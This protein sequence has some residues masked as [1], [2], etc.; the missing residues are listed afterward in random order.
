MV[1]FYYRLKQFFIGFLVF[2][3]NFGPMNKFF[4][5]LIILLSSF[6]Q[7]VN[8]QQ[9]TV[10]CTPQFDNSIYDT[11]IKTVKFGTINN[12]HSTTAGSPDYTYFN[13]PIADVNQCQTYTLTV[14]YE[15]YSTSTNISAFFDFNGDGNFSGTAEVFSLKTGRGSLTATK[16]ITIPSTAP[17]KRIRMRIV[18]NE[19][20]TALACDDDT[21][22][23]AEDYELLVKTGVDMTFQSASV[24]Q[25][26]ISVVKQG[27]TKKEILGVN[28]ITQN[29][30]NP[31]D[32]TDMT[33]ATTGSTDP[34]DISNA[35]L[36]YNTTNDFSG[37]TVVGGT[38]VSP[39]GNFTIS[40]IDGGV[41]G[42]AVGNNY[43]W[44]AY[45]ISA[46]AT[47]KNFVDAELIDIKTNEGG[48]S[49]VT[50][51]NSNP[52]GARE[53]IYQHCVPV[54]DAATTGDDFELNSYSLANYTSRAAADGFNSNDATGYNNYSTE[55]SLILCAGSSYAFTANTTN[56]DVNNMAFV[57]FWADWN[58]DGDF[59]DLDEHQVLGATGLATSAIVLITTTNDFTTV[60]RVPEHAKNGYTVARV[61]LSTDAKNISCGN[62]AKGE[63][64][65]VLIR[66]NSF[67]TTTNNY[68]YNEDGSAI[69]LSQTPS[70][71]GYIWQKSTDLV[72]FT[73]EAGSNDALNLGVIPTSTVSAYRLNKVVAECPTDVDGNTFVQSGVTEVLKV[74]LDSVIAVPTEVCLG[75]SSYLK[76]YYGFKSQIFTDAPADNFTGQGGAYTGTITVANTLPT[77]KFNLS[78]VCVDITASLIEDLAFEL[79]SPSGKKVMLFNGSSVNAASQNYTFC[80][81]LDTTLVNINDETA[82]LSGD[83]QPLTS[84]SRLS[85]ETTNGDWN[86]NI[87]SSN[88]AVDATLNSWSMQFGHNHSIDWTDATTFF[89]ASLDSSKAQVNA[90]QYFTAS[91]NS[92]L[93]T[94][95]NFIDSVEVISNDP[96]NLSIDRFESIDGDLLLCPGAD[97]Q[98]K[99][100]LTNPIAGD[101]Y[102]WYVNDV[103]VVGEDRDSIIINTLN[104]GDELKVEFTLNSTCGTLFATDSVELFER[105][106]VIPAIDLTSSIVGPLCDPTDFTIDAAFTDTLQQAMYS[107]RINANEVAQKVNTYDFIGLNNGDTIFVSVT[108]SICSTDYS[109]TDTIIY[110]YNPRVDIVGG[111]VDNLTEYCFGNTSL[112]FDSTGNNVSGQFYWVL[113]SDTIS[114]E[115]AINL[116]TLDAGNYDIS[117]EYVPYGCFTAT[118][119]TETHSFEILEILSPAITIDAAVKILCP[120]EGVIIKSVVLENAGVNPTFTWYQNGNKL[121][122]ETNDSLE[123]IN[124]NVAKTYYVELES[125][126]LCPDQSKV[127][128]NILKI[129]VQ[130]DAVVKLNSSSSSPVMGCVDGDDVV[131]TGTLTDA[132]ADYYYW[133]AND[134]IIPNSN[135][136][137]VTFPRDSGMYT[138]RLYGVRDFVCAGV[139][140]VESS[141]IHKFENYTAPDSTFVMNVVAGEYVASI[142]DTSSEATAMWYLN[143]KFISANNVA[144]I[145][146]TKAL[147]TLCVEVSMAN[148]CVTSSCQ[149]F[150]FVGVEE[151]IVNNVSVYPNPSKSILNI[152]WSGISENG[153]V[154][155]TIINQVGK[156]IELGELKNASISVEGLAKGSYILQLK[157]NDSYAI[158]RFE[159]M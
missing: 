143:G 153:V 81:T 60:I 16:Q 1:A 129:E 99:A 104:D 133:T 36:Y 64:D 37:A 45:N 145:V 102:T 48:G 110:Q 66:V 152:Q 30:C 62:F 106:A 54:V 96:G 20:S 19:N 68:A 116:D 22:G 124:Q 93:T 65:D 101:N 14:T 157:S 128:S 40:N 77:S 32:V 79:E 10:N 149:E 141:G 107:W 47:N 13:T 6:A 131:L 41:N 59:D 2:G 78:K 25:G 4:T 144:T 50:A 137:N 35:R 119:L 52:S 5:F 138:Y 123:I 113:N 34:S 69:T 42:L 127:T 29:A 75:D 98:V 118:N 114:N 136:L 53:I 154:E 158:K 26:P 86:L 55:D 74:G 151:Q 71:S 24:S 12:N 61:G 23:E 120:L 130:K 46:S 126:Y 150:S 95:T 76:S 111:L 51:S 73:D 117:V 82:A 100:I 3:C 8:A 43:F 84:W 125:D 148:T 134:T 89:N 72:S 139:D 88:D 21:Y 91:L 121:N 57:Q 56:S 28:V 142:N 67:E 27:E 122:F 103:I 132:P 156:T 97:K 63:F 85:G 87:L 155:Y 58:Q 38:A 31:I 140:T 70:I 112:T 92:D 11:Y 15:A 49:L 44:L 135:S 90:T 17:T 105:P 109:D 115:D 147:N 9:S 18:V 7:R 146:F 33:F 80:V 108:Q 39:N 83:Y 94:G 159:K